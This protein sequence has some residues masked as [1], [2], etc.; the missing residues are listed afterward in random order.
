MMKSQ[1]FSVYDARA[2]IFHPP[3]LT[4]NQFT[5]QRMIADVVNSPD[6]SF[7]RHP[8]DYQLFELGEFDDQTGLYVT[9][10]AKPICVL[11]ELLRKEG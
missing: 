6:H 10:Q 5:A 8:A 9:H 1:V 11:D 3:F 2:Q 4:H 7:H